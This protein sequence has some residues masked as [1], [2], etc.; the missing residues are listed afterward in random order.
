MIAINI[1]KKSFV[2]DF[3]SRYPT[4]F[5]KSFL[6]YNNNSIDKP[7]KNANFILSKRVFNLFN[8]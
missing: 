2:N 4:V 3:Q 5:K 6:K 8:G 1:K 7:N